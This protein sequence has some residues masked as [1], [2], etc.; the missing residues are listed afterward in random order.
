MP[1][2]PITTDWLAIVT[3]PTTAAG[4][5]FA[6]FVDTLTVPF[7]VPL[8]GDTVAH[9]APVDAVQAQFDGMAVM[10][11]VPVPPPEANGLPN[12]DVSSEKLHASGCS[13]IVNGLPPII[14]VP[15]RETVVEFPS[16][17]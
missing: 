11:I 4:A 6:A 12:F 3:V 17:E 5:L 15:E 13:V 10:P 8:G 9:E 7:P 14:S 1:T 16:T 2:F